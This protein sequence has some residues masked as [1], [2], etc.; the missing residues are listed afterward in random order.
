MNLRSPIQDYAENL[1]G[2]LVKPKC[3]V[4]LPIFK[5]YLEKNWAMWGVAIFSTMSIMSTKIKDA[6][7]KSRKDIPKNE[8]E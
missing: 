4:L 7:D 8:K 3:Q 6:K 1:D 2:L 5:K